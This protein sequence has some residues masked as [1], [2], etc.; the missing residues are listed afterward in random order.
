MGNL[1]GKLFNFYAEELVH[2]QANQLVYVQRLLAAVARHFVAGTQHFQLQQAQLAVADDEEVAA[3]TG[4]VKKRQAAQLFMEIKQAVFVVFYL[5]KLGPQ[6]IQKQRA[7]QLQNVFFTGVMRPQIAP[8]L[9][10]HNAL[11]QA[12]KNRGAD[13]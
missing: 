2:I 5:V 10:V 9:G 8:R 6:R 4:R 13:A 11:E 3:A 12:A 7:Y 1:G